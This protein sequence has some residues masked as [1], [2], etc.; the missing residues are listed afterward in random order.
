MLINNNEYLNIIESV[1][2]EIKN[3]QYKAAVSVNK[4]LVLLYYIDI[5]NKSCQ[6]KKD[7]I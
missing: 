4:E 1:K 7:V 6:N 2:S 5:P 3:A